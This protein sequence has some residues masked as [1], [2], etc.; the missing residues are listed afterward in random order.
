ML[1]LLEVV[2]AL[3]YVY[4]LLAL[5]VGA[6]REVIAQL[7]GQRGKGLEAALRDMLG[8][9]AP[10]KKPPDSEATQSDALGERVIRHELLRKVREKKTSRLEPATFSAAVLDQLLDWTAPGEPGAPRPDADADVV[11][12]RPPESGDRR[13]LDATLA[14]GLDARFARHRASELTPLETAL[15]ALWL[16]AHRDVAMFREELEAWFDEVMVS[17]TEAYRKR[18]YGIMFLL[19]LVVVGTGNVDTLRITRQLWHDA[20]TRDAVVTLA[21]QAADAPDGAPLPP[22]DAAEALQKVR[23][24]FERL[25]FPW[26]WEEELS[27]R[28]DPWDAFAVLSKGCGLALT[29]LAASL[30]APFWF[31]VL[32]QLASLRPVTRPRRPK[33]RKESKAVG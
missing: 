33:E 15:R 8:S 19:S 14:E 1:L 5:A 7:L 30:G 29:V 2:L 23:A 12:G 10:P 21:T 24:D 6:A 20:A 13:E 28:T 25:G 22:E 26:G 31:D 4:L 27:Q 9:D 16:R 11:E 18:T 32:R 3:A 17:A